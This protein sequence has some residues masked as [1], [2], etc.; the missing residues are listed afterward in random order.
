MAAQPK[1]KPLWLDTEPKQWNKPGANIPRGQR[2]RFEEDEFMRKQCLPGVRQP[3]TPEA[4]AVVARGW[5]LAT[6]TH[7]N[8]GINVVTGMQDFDGMCRPMRYQDF[9]FVDGKYA[10]TLSPQLMDSRTTGASIRAAFPDPGKIYAEFERYNI[11]DPLCC[12]SRV[13][14]A[15]YEI[16]D[17]GGKPVVALV[18]VKTRP[19]N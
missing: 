10:G 5:M 9:V 13:S 4:R 16:R 2:S 12:P 8:R 19:A 3:M 15:T 11:S 18:S 7:D 6:E 17:A 1:E 14:E